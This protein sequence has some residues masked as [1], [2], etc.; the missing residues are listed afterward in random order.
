M[1]KLLLQNAQIAT[2]T[3][4][5]TGDVL[6]EGEVIAA[7]G[8][9]L[10]AKGATVINA[11][12]KVLL[13]GGVD[14]HTHFDLDV[15]FT[16][17]SDDFYTGSIAAACGGTTTV[18]DHMAF[19]PAG[20]RLTHQVEVYHQ[21]AQRAVIDYGL[22]GVIQ[23]VDAQVLKDM[24]LLR[25]TEGI[26][27]HKV[28]LTY[29]DMLNDDET[30]QVLQ[31]A[32]QLKL[33]I[34]AHCENDAI[35]NALRAKFVA[36]GKT[37]AEYHPK[38]R[39]AEAEAEAVFRFL[40]LAKAAGEAKAYVVHLSTALGLQAIQLMRENGQQNIFAETCPQY[41][42]LDDTLYSDPTE[43]LKYLIS[44]PL[45]TP[46]DE[47]MLWGGLQTGNI[48]TIGTDHCP[49]FFKTQKQRGKDNFTLAPNGAPGVE[50][51]MA[52]LFSEGYKKGRLTLPEVVRTCC[53]RP[54]E[55][56][57]VAPQKGDIAVGAD[58]DLVLFNPDAKWQVT[59]SRLHENVD[60]TPYEGMQLCGRP[61]MTIARG[62]IIV[63]NGKF[64]GGEGRGRYL[65]RSV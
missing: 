35:V 20:C 43:G 29:A 60:Y 18:I 39:P 21:L 36:A 19:G 5:F 31:R 33:T 34:C 42:L 15:G 52:L 27:S 7:V 41:L 24:K 56:F 49:F 50:L 9:N 61:I 53:T 47:A 65:R 57:G 55:I 1:K 13:P 23:H 2:S 44:P 14:P 45:R 12:G 16:R 32:K 46:A 10:P 28:Y 51:R 63:E 22:H 37:A 54:A 64:V 4:V 8:Q 58:A 6:L 38:S 3:R 26:T 48:D 62:E 59:Q 11:T 25:D 17:A 30:L 40:S